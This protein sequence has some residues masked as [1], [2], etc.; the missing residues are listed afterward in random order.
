MLSPELWGVII[1][2][3]IGGSIGIVTTG[4][5]FLYNWKQYRSQQR[6]DLRQGVYIEA[7]AAMARNVEYLASVWR[8]DLDEGQL[9]Q[10]LYP[11]TI[12]AN[13]IQ[14]VGTQ[15]TIDALA[16][17]SESFG[18]SA[19]ELAKTKAVL[20]AV[21]ARVAATEAEVAQSRAYVQQLVSMIDGLPKSAPTAEVLAAIPGL[22]TEFTGA[23][24]R[25]LQGQARLDAASRETVTLQKQL[26]MEGVKAA[27]QYQQELLEVN[28]AVRRELDL[29]LDEAKYRSDAKKSAERMLAVVER[30][31]KELEAG[32]SAN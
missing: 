29:P 13:K 22:V 20:L 5:G 31:V 19:L 30:T 32:G 21:Q 12:A 25:V 24:D 15:T 7:A 18:V 4:L 17:A 6:F 9:A 2:G 8:T 26:L 23:R 28:I 3:I 10:M 14:V 11:G 1:G 27:V 16:K